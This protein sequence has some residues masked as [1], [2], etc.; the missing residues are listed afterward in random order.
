MSRIIFLSLFTLLLYSCHKELDYD[1]LGFEPQIVLNGL[2]YQDSVI[3]INV[4]RTKSILESNKVFP[5]LNNA[6]VRLYENDVY[7]ENLIFDSLGYYHSTITTKANTQ[8]RIE[9]QTDEIE[10][11]TAEFSFKEITSFTLANITYRTLDTVISY[12]DIT[13]GDIWYR[14]EHPEIT[15]PFPQK[16]TLLTQV[17]LDF[18]I[19]FNDNPDEENY[20]T[21]SNYGEFYHL[22]HGNY[23]SN[24]QVVEARLLK[25][26]SSGYLRFRN[27][28]DRDLYFPSGSSSING[29]GDGGRYMNDKR[30]NGQEVSLELN[31]SYL[32]G[33]LE[34]IE[35]YLISYPSDYIDFH[36]SGYR[37]IE[38]NDNPFSQPSNVLTNVEN[39]LGIVCAVSNSKQIIEFTP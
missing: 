22:E 36:V 21:Y 9:A 35:V 33:K 4:S 8:Y 15:D 2:I 31:T 6:E 3:V 10:T 28:R 18:D 32:T 14:L 27:H 30:F 34:P 16:D 11:A 25:K 29:Y 19:V 23:H 26:S 37:Y 5:L 12:D 24:D 1:D 17:I 13:E 20:Y 39:G 7:V 38:A